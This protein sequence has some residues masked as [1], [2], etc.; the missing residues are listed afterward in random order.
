MNSGMSIKS[1]ILLIDKEEGMSSF[2]VVKRVKE[3]LDIRKAGHGGTLDPFATGLLI[4]LLGQGTKLQPYLLEYRKI[5]HATVRLGVETDTG[6]P[7]GNVIKEIEVPIISPEIIEQVFKKLTGEIIQ[8][9][10]SYSAVKNRGIPSYRLARKGIRTEIKKKKVN[11]YSIKL[12]SKY[13]SELD[14][15]VEC[16]SGTYIRS[17]GV[18]I[19]RMLDNCAHVKKLKRVSIGPF[20]LKDAIS[21]SM[22]N[23]R[24]R[25]ILINKIIPLERALPLH[26]Y[27]P[28]DEQMAKRVRNGHN[29]FFKRDYDSISNGDNIK[30]IHNEKLIAIGRVR[31]LPSGE[32]I[33]VKLLRVFNQDNN[34]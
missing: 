20:N 23:S 7:E 32:G 14:I 11:I 10:P 13:E 26:K 28:V 16:S 33:Y 19:G 5:Y 2:Q 1:G 30:L 6:D 12:L 31:K 3:C 24:Q 29:P 17:L 27:L 18:Q 9:V 4:I 22:I 21:S 25:G 34:N 8:D 15:E